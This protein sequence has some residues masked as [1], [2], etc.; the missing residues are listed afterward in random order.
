MLNGLNTCFESRYDSSFTM[1]MRCNDKARS[2]SFLD[3]CSEFRWGE[4]WR[5]WTVYATHYPKSEKFSV[6]VGPESSTEISFEGESKTV[7]TP[8]SRRLL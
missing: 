4:L 6:N 7:I 5:R 1:T 2:G 8:Q 3:H